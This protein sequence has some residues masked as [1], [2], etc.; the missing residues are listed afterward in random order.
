MG[1]KKPNVMREKTHATIEHDAVP[2]VAAET[3]VTRH[4]KIVDDAGNVR[5]DMEVCT[6]NADE[7]GPRI[8][9][10][11]SG[12]RAAVILAVEDGHDADMVHL[13]MAGEDDQSISLWLGGMRG[14]GLDLQGPRRRNKGGVRLELLAENDATF[15]AAHGK[16]QQRTLLQLVPGE[17]LATFV[18]GVVDQS[19][20][21]S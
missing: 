12:G 9:L 11:G 17:E 3:V 19:E 8:K 1:D 20:V 2:I 14:P 6:D 18:D 4:L 16:G 21:K 5:I 15:I 10:F 7:A 13:W